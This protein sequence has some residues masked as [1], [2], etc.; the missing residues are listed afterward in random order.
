MSVPV[1]EIEELKRK[2][3]L[4]VTLVDEPEA[5]RL[6]G[7]SDSD[8]GR[9]LLSMWDGGKLLR[10]EV[11]GRPAYPLFQFDVDRQ[12]IL[13]GLSAILAERSSGYSDYRVVHWLTTPHL[14]FGRTPAEAI[15]SN[16]D[17]VL[18]AFRRELDP[19]CHG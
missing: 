15:S 8:P 18:A 10:F 4:K 2:I 13:S 1:P 5:V 6:L 19:P 12:C 17:A 16:S 11:D 14:D 3:L 7:L 9:T